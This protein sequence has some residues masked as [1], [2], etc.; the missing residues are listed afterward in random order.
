MRFSQIIHN[1]LVQLSTLWSAVKLIKR[2]RVGCFSV[3]LVTLS[4]LEARLLDHSCYFIVFLVRDSLC[5][6][7]NEMRM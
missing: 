4:Y 7:I 5:S 3:K 1:F 2:L 6:I